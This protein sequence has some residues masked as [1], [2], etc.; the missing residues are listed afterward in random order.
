MKVLLTGASGGIGEHFATAFARRGYDLVLVG[1]NE[2]KLEEIS[3]RIREKFAVACTVY[4]CDLSRKEQIA[5]LIESHPETDVLV[6][7]AAVSSYGPC[8]QLPWE[9]IERMIEVNVLAPVRLLHHYVRGMI[10]RRGGKIL[11]VS[12]TAGLHAVPFMAVYAATKS[13]LCSISEAVAGE[14]GDRAITVA[15]ILPGP[16][17]TDFWYRQGRFL[18]SHLRMDKYASPADVAETGV[19]LLEQGRIWGI[20]GVL[21]RIKVAIKS[22]LPQRLRLALL[23]EHNKKYVAQ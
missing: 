13:F 15:C 10:Q 11:N 2:R 19:K 5:G 1:R 20:V 18:T 8:D 14:V 9:D 17:A 22:S 16:T 21:N 23:K 6:N 7:N 4:V 12:S 3:C